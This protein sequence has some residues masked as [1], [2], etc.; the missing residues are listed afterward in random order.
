MDYILI[1]GVTG[2]IGSNICIELYKY[3]QNIIVIDNYS[4]SFKNIESIVN[5]FAPKIK[6]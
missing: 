6:K 4:N 5:K 2:Y 1:T 3:T